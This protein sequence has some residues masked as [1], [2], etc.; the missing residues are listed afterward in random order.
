M[1][2]TAVLVAAALQSAS[3]APRWPAGAPILVWVDMTAAPAGA[4]ALVER[5]LARWSESVPGRITLTR[6]REKADGMI[7][8]RFASGGNGVYGEAAPRIDPHTG[9][10]VAADVVIATDTAGDDPLTRQIVIYL[11]ALHE[12]GHAIG[13]RH[14]DTFT[15]IMYRF[16]RPDDGERYFMAYRRRLRSANDV[17]SAQVT[18]LSADDLAAVRRLY[19]R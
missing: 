5:A 7:R 17:G 11:T 3:L 10:I 19:D 4:G 2:I 6:T 16:Q 12:I 18:G 1:T 14:T 8:V 15:D 9:A 13:L